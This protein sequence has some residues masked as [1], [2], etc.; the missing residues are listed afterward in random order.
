MKLFKAASTDR[1]KTVVREVDSS[2]EKAAGAEMESNMANTFKIQQNAGSLNLFDKQIGIEYALRAGF[3][4]F[5]C[6]VGVARDKLG[7]GQAQTN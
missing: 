7:H 6:P 4:T 3:M 1:L 5:H 2:G